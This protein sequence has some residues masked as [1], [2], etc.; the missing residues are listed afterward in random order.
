VIKIPFLQ[1]HTSSIPGSGIINP[2]P[3]QVAAAFKKCKD[4]N[5]VE[6][7]GKTGIN[8]RRCSF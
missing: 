4:E 2:V 6:V 1:L 7:V 5:V 3:I 8:S